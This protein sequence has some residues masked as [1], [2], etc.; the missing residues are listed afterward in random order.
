MVVDSMV[1]LD[2]SEAEQPIG[3]RVYFGPVLSYT[4]IS[5]MYSKG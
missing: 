3:K 1:S 5:I 2:W 4:R